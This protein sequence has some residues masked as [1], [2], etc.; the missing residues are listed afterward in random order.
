M[1]LLLLSFVLVIQLPNLAEFSL[2]NSLL[3]QTPLTQ[4]EAMSL[5]DQF[6]LP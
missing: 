4:Q 1:L 6:L 2:K 5:E 3:Y